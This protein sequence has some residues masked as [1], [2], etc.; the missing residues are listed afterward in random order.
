MSAVPRGQGDH[1]GVQAEAR[2]GQRPETEVIQTVEG[3]AEDRQDGQTGG[4]TG[5]DDQAARQVDVVHD[6][7]AGVV[8]RPDGGG[9]DEAEERGDGAGGGE[10]D[11]EQHGTSGVGGWL[12]RWPERNS[13]QES[14][15]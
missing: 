2:E 7:F 10:P 4:E 13:G 15:A 3:Q 12:G 9:Q 1:A 14:I 8:D 11:E 6:R 5:H